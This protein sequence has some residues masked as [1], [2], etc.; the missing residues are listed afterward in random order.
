MDAGSSCDRFG[1][2]LDVQLFLVCVFLWLNSWFIEIERLK[3]RVCGS[4]ACLCCQR[5]LV[6]DMG[7]EKRKRTKT[8]WPHMGPLVRRQDAWS[9]F[10][11]GSTIVIAMVLSLEVMGVI[12][13]SPLWVMRINWHYIC[14]GSLLIKYDLQTAWQVM[15]YTNHDSITRGWTRRRICV[16]N[17]E[18]STFKPRNRNLLTKSWEFDV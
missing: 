15:V 9:S 18:S 7:K 1:L 11:Y 4:K 8:G 2:V 12:L 17:H 3:S 13:W 16:Q 5:Q 6:K 14:G 10:A